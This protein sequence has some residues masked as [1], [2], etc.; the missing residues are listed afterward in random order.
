MDQLQYDAIDRPAQLRY[1]FLLYAGQ[2]A[3]KQLQRMCLSMTV[4][5]ALQLT[6]T[7]WQWPMGTEV[8]QVKP[9]LVASWHATMQHMNSIVICM[10]KEATGLGLQAMWI[11]QHKQGKH[12]HSLTSLPYARNHSPASLWYSYSNVTAILLP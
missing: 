1:Y 4:L 5:T 12:R 9:I 2:M 8:A 7:Y 6:G 3:L 10:Q 11:A